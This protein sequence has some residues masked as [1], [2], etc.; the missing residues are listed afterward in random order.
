LEVFDSKDV[1][2][3]TYNVVAKPFCY[4]LTLEIAIETI[5]LIS[6]IKINAVYNCL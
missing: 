6:F 4:V 2:I 3:L 1:L 5:D